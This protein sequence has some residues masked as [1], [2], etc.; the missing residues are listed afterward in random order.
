MHKISLA[1]YIGF[2]EIIIKNFYRVDDND[3][4]HIGNLA[5]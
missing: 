3:L 1:S 5:I 2:G 4:I